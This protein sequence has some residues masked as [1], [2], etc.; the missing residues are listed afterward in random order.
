MG[1]CRTLNGEGN[2][3]ILQYVQRGGSYLG[4]CAGGYYG[5]ARCEFEVGD[6]KMEVIGSREL[7]FFPGTCRGCAFSG[8]VYHSEKGARAVELKVDKSAVAVGSIPDVFRSYYNGGGV[9]VD[10]PKYKDKGVEVLASYSER[11][12]V[13]SGEGAAAV[14]YCKSGEGAAILTGPHPEFVFSEKP[15]DNWSLTK[16][17]F[18]AVNLEKNADVPGFDKVID[19]LAEDE[20]HRMDFLKACLS[21]LGLQVNSEDNAVPSLSRIHL[22]SQTP[23]DTAE[24]LASLQNIISIVDGEEYIKDDNDTFHLEKPSTWSMN[25]LKEVIGASDEKTDDGDAGE[26]RIVDYNAIVKRIVAHEKD[27]PASKE[28][29]YFNHHAFYA[30]LDNY[31]TSSKEGEGAFGKSIMYGEVV[32]STN[33]LLEK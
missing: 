2:R 15:V 20:K 21:K 17:R 19:T 30:N 18:A 31:Q 33:T 27:Y 7:A 12:D 14:V 5:T 4:L 1:Y 11:L 3:R 8:F 16:P 6:K 24:L 26:D 32:T 13:D 28:T 23:S 10:A 29:P 25:K 22:S 9:F